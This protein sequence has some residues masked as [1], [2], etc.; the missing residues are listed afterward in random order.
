M[1]LWIATLVEWHALFTFLIV[2]PN[3]LLLDVQSQ[4]YAQIDP[5]L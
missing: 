4:V 5:K 2:R 3:M 1:S